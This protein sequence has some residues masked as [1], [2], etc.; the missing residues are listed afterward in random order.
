LAA[1]QNHK[2][3]MENRDNAVSIMAVAQIL[4]GSA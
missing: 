4:K 2:D 1:E 3:A